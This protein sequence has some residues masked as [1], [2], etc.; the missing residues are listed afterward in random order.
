MNGGLVQRRGRCRLPRCARLADRRIRDL[1]DGLDGLSR[2]F[3]GRL[4][5]RGLGRLGTDMLD[6]S[7]PGCRFVV[8]TLGLLPMLVISTV[9]VAALFPELM[10]PGADGGFAV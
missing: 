7:S 5:G 2:P 8:F 9:S 1:G 4:R 6:R 10:G 3:P